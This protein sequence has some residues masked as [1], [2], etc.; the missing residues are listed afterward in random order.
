MKLS[1]G[2]AEFHS[3]QTENVLQFGEGVF[4]RGFVDWQIQKMNEKGYFNGSVVAVNPRRTGNAPKLNEQDGLFTVSLQ[5]L[6]HGEIVKTSSVVSCVQRGVHPY[7]Q[8]DEYIKIAE[9]E[10]LR[11][12]ISNTTEAGIAFREEDKLEDQPQESFPGKVAAFLYHR[13]HFLTL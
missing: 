1:R 9:N 12:V 2:N 8:Y 10:N 5:G 11:F 13:Y 6:Q 3:V 4:L 7:K